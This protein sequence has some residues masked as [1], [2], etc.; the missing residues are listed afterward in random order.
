M[1]D[2]KINVVIGANLSELIEGMRTGAEAVEAG[3]LQM[4]GAMAGLNAA[5]EAAMAPLIAFMAV[6]QGGKFI[7]EAVADAMALN[8]EAVG[9]GKQLGVSANEAGQLSM[10]LKQVNGSTEGFASATTM[11]TRQIRQNEDGV[12]A[13][14]LQTRNADGSLR[15]SKDLMLDAIEVLKGYREGT[16]RN[17]AAQVLFGR[18]ASN[19]GPILKVNKDLL[20]E[21]KAKQ[22]ALGLTITTEGEERTKKYKIAMAEANEVMEAVNVKIGNALMPALTKLAEWFGSVGPTVVGV[23]GDAMDVMGAVMSAIGEVAK[24]LWNNVTTAF[25]DMGAIVTDVFGK[26]APG[27]VLT[28]DN[29]LKVLRVT[30]FA[31]TQ[32]IRLAADVMMLAVGTIISGVQVAVDA[33][34][35]LIYGGLDG[36]KAG[37][38]RGLAALEARFRESYSR[39]ISDAVGAKSKFDEIWN[40]PAKAKEHPDDKA[41]K[42]GGNNQFNQANQDDAKAAQIVKGW[43]NALAAIKAGLLEQS[44]RENQ[45]HEMSAAA[46]S[47]YWQRIVATAANGSKEKAAAVAKYEAARISELTKRYAEEKAIGEQFIAGNQAAQLAVLDQRQVLVDREVALGRMTNAQKIAADQQFEADK[48]A[49]Q[50]AGFNARLA[51]LAKDPTQGAAYAAMLNAK[52]AL[53]AQYEAKKRAL[54]TQTQVESAKGLRAGI[55]AVSQSWAQ[56]LAKMATYQQTFAG[57]IQSMWQGLV[58]AIEQAI[59]RMLANDIAQW[60]T[61]EATKMGL[62]KASGLAT[63]SNEAALAGAGGVASMA[64]APFPL[65]TTAPAFG[66]S[67]AAAAMAFTPA[68]AK[69]FD[70][71]RGVNPVTQLHEREMVLP[72]D[73]ADKVRN[74]TGGGGNVHLHVHAT[75]AQSVRR[76]FENN[77]DV[78][79]R[80]MKDMH[81]NGR[82]N[83]GAMG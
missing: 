73:L 70:I 1:S 65:N 75:D 46:E 51:L 2:D 45:N 50:V 82:L 26:Q 35:G 62:I 49:V 80:V 36:M 74:S 8:K 34:K 3:T 77:G 14:G 40:A 78:L 67:M 17:M 60:A 42:G 20:E 28:F 56:S 61:A 16:D 5:F 11:L 23:F 63:V 39:I 10:A 53:D 69:G 9:L 37:A 32:A 27:A 57:T 30:L 64:A 6:L 43:E 4:K 41:N 44:V 79:A 12:K 66:A 13:M 15:N 29:A 24:I 21:M 58:Q 31:I 68:A 47:A 71:P 25:A 59:T 19:L 7:G 48:Y 54:E 55:D 52:L 81:R 33:I 76:L 22:E 83:G 72:A 18:G 38:A